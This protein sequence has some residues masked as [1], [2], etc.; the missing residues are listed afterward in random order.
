M[1]EVSKDEFYASFCNLNVTT[2][3]PFTHKI[4]EVRLRNNNELIA[5]SIE[6]EGGEDKFY[7]KN[8][9]VS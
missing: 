6:C 1:K 5:K 8:S 4:W 7:I 3:C 9:P 2:G